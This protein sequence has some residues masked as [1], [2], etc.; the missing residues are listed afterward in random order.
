MN[1]LIV[2]DNSI[3]LKLLRAQLEDE[4]HAVFEAHNGVD[5]L[6]LLERQPVDVLISDIFMPEMDG[7]RLCYE[8]RKHARLHALPIILCTSTYTSVEDEKLVRDVGADKYLTRPVSFETFAAAV[9]E[10]KAKGHAGPQHK[11]MQEAE[12]LKEYSERLVSKLEEK[13]TELQEKI[14]ALTKEIANR[15]R[16]EERFQSLFE[17]APDA[18]VM[19]DQQGII[20][21]V[22]RQ[23]EAMFGYQRDELLGQPVEVLMPEAFRRAHVDLRQGFLGNAMPRAMGVGR[24]DF[25]G[26]RKDGTAFPM[27]ISLSPMESERGIV[28]AAAVRD[29]TQRLKSEAALREREARLRTIIDN[30]PECVKVVDKNGL[31]LE[32][33]PAG[34]RMIEADSLL[35]AQNE[36]INRVIVEEHRA[37]FSALL[38]KTL[39][40]ESGILEFDIIGLKGTRRTLDTHAVPLRDERGEVTA[41]LGI[42][43]D[44]TEHK[45]DQEE[46]LRLNAELEDRV[47]RRTTQLQMANQ[48]LEAFSYSV[49]HDLRT[50]LSAIDGFSGLLGKEIGASAVSERGKHY[51]ARI[52]AG[53][54]QMGELIDALLSLA[55]VSRASLHWDS[56]DLSAMAETVLNGYWERD[57]ERVTQLD[58]Q[59]GLLGQGD[60]L[61]LRQV[62]DNLLGNAW[63]FSGQQPQTHIAFGRESGPDGQIVYTVRDQG[64]GFDMAYSEKLFGAFQRLHSVSEFSGTGIGLATVHRIITLHG[65]RVWAESTPG[66]GATFYFTL[67]DPP[68]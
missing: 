4:G 22:N 28:V 32:M 21:L 31:I 13:N 46:I 23:A 12:V 53:V 54:V 37:A 24:A 30:E 5:A 60:P 14:E 42:T 45:Q 20:T 58:I 6:A 19:I 41:L 33:N 50:P 35:Q 66:Q 44:I 38:R 18:V 2:D 36:G 65:G 7:Y 47:R 68:A 27:E 8:I 43:R 10:V 39:Q 67:G 49:S 34:L 11:T 40:G 3:N 61:L 52:R 25:L 64:V 15:K 59:P 63:K 55:Q 1:I 17:F 57:P 56:V 16:A 29:V 48:E 9:H 51:L 26:L 62:L